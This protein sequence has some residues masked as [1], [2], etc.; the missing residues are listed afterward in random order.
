MSRWERALAAHD[1]A[2]EACV[3]AARSI[4][5][6]EWNAR[7]DGWSPSQVLRHVALAY[8]MVL[9]DLDGRHPSVRVHGLRQLLWRELALPVVLGTGKFPR[10][11]A[12]REIRPGEEALTFDESVAFLR[13]HAARCKSALIEAKNTRPRYR[14]THPYFGRISIL[15]MLRLGNVHT[16]HHARKLAR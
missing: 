4:P 15:S 1:E 10:I 12:P 14:P 2:I 9:S 11:E 5:G 13:D 8:V 7:G 3:A 6:E 16:A